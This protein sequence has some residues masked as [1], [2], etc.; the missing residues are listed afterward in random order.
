MHN[1]SI[2]THRSQARQRVSARRAAAY[3]RPADGSLNPEQF[4]D[5]RVKLAA[6]CPE[7]ALMYAVLENC[8]SLLS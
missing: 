2:T 4:F 6:V 8:V 5:S 3:E 1:R 7:T